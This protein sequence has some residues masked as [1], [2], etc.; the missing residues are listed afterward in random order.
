MQ[1]KY[2]RLR[3]KAIGLVIAF[4]LIVQLMSSSVSAHSSLLGGINAKIEDNT[5][6]IVVTMPEARTLD[7]SVL[8]QKYTEETFVISNNDKP[9]SISV[10]DFA[11]GNIA[12]ALSTQITLSAVCEE[13][14][15]NLSVHSEYFLSEGYAFS[16]TFEKAGVAHSVILNDTNQDATFVFTTTPKTLQEKFIFGFQA[17][18]QFIWLG[19][20]HIY[21]GLDHTLFIVA[22]ILG[23][24]RF[25]PLFKTITAFTIAHSITLILSSLN[26]AN[27]IPSIV[28][29]L[30]ALS[31]AYVALEKYILAGLRH[32]FK[33][34][35]TDIT[36]HRWKVAF[37]FGLIHGLGFASVLKEV[38]IPEHLLP[39]S[40]V[41]FNVGVEIGQLTII[42]I[43]FPMLYLISKT[44][45]QKLFSA[46]ASIF[47]GLVGITWF[48]GRVFWGFA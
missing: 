41:S 4:P 15:E 18:S 32:F 24:F 5:I 39:V 21:T 7:D 27:L 13:E 45:W 9:C 11:T 35:P 43:V 10:L 17:A 26:V 47:I 36:S 12:E 33:K 37:G 46:W 20:L 29:P 34:I 6:S 44:R 8:F 2:F 48:I 23:V 16:A 25:W 30:I 22:L 19:M 42:A 1:E 28:E 31:I 40:L 3:R 14:I 38:Q